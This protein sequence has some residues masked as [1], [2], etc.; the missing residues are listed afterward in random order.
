MPQTMPSP[1][2]TPRFCGHV[3][4]F[5]A[6]MAQTAE[7][8]DIALCGIPFDSGTLGRNGSRLGPRAVRDVSMQAIR[9]V[10]PLSN[11]SPFENCRVA[12][13]GDAVSNP[14]DILE[15]MDQIT[16]FFA[17]I[18]AT[19]A[20]PLTIGGDHLVS[21]PVLRALAKE[22]PVGLVHF[23]LHTDTYEGFYGQRY[24]NGTTFRRAIEEG[25]VDPRRSLQIGIRGPRF[26]KEDVAFSLSAGMRVITIDEFF[27]LGTSG[28]AA[29]IRSIA[30]GPVYVS[31]DIDAIDSVYV[32]GTGAPEIGG[33]TPRDAQVMIRG[34]GGL[35][36]IGADM[37]EVSPALDPTDGT[38][39]VAANLAFELLDVMAAEVIARRGTG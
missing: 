16:A 38:A 21:L 2:N 34:L 15:A 18:H 36:I 22:R 29:E 37:V 1:L 39:R 33:Y 24:N 19:G 9:P 23:D 17:A 8:V 27:E 3:S 20:L 32:P 30:R 4:L 12:D 28:V 10:H 7:G 13:V 6:P 35:D 14:L 26:G 11:E 25:L 5:R 31:F